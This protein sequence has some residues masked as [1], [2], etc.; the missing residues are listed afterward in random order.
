M[1]VK[2]KALAGPLLGIIGAALL[3]MA[4]IVGFG[5]QAIR[6][7]LLIVAGLSWEDIGFD[8]MLFT[9]SAVLTLVWSLLGLIGAI[10]SLMGK[11][12]GGFLMLICGTIATIGM[13]IPIGTYTILSVEY[14]VFLNS[15]FLFV[16]PILLLLGGVLGLVFREF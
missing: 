4:G 13:F 16:D 9:V 14:T 8:P 12:F 7:N 6:E 5:T 15:H 3:L 2:G 1:V 11:K 10:L